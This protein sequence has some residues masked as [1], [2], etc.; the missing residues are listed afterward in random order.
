MPST[1]IPRSRNGAGSTGANV[2]EKTG[3]RSSSTTS[4]N[5]SSEY[6]GEKR[7]T[8]NGRSPSAARTERIV[9]R[10]SSGERIAPAID[11]N[12]PARDTAMASSG[13]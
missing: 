6:G 5:A 11:P 12:P 1:T 2:Y 3:G 10:S 13:D 8:A 4:Y 9:S 7:L